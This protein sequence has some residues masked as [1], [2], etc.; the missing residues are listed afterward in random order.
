MVPFCTSSDEN[1]ATQLLIDH[2]AKVNS[3][4][5]KGATPLIIAAVKGHHSVLRILANHPQ[6]QLHVQVSNSYQDLK[7]C[8]GL[9]ANVLGCPGPLTLYPNPNPTPNPTPIPNLGRPRTPYGSPSCLEFSW[10]EHCPSLNRHCWRTCT[11]T[12]LHFAF[13]IL[14]GTQL[15]TALCWRR[16]TNQSPSYWKLVLIQLCLIF[17]CLHQFMKQPGLDFYRKLMSRVIVSLVDG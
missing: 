15:S 8:P 11:S 14:M 1:E 12:H 10:G 9:P 2:G 7:G 16:R 4:N 6:I 3:T 5:K 17:D 13:R